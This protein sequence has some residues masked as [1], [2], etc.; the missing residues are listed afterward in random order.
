MYARSRQSFGE[1]HGTVVERVAQR[2]IALSVARKAFQLDS[3]SVHGLPMSG[4]GTKLFQSRMMS[5]SCKTPGLRGSELGWGIPFNEGVSFARL[6]D[7]K[8][9][10]LCFS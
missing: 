3:Q 2:K 9:R 6:R 8:S 1:L 7:L 4:H 5:A 10:I